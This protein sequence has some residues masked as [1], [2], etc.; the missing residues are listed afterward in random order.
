MQ[1]DH[2]PSGLDASENVH[3]GRNRCGNAAAHLDFTLGPHSALRGR[4]QNLEAIA[5]E[6]HGEREPPCGAR[7]GRV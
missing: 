7:P 4:K 6:D 1:V 3:Y 5:E 2:K